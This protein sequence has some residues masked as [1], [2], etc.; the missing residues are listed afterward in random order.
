MAT[1]DDDGMTFTNFPY[2]VSPRGDDDESSV[3]IYDGLD[4]TPIISVKSATKVTPARSSLNLFDEILIEEGT[5]KEASYND[6]QAEHEKCQQQLQELT[7]KLQEIQEQN[8]ALQNEN[9]SLKKNISA[10]IKTARVEINRKDEEISNLQRRL[11]EFSVHQNTYART[12]FSGSTNNARNF[13]GSKM[14]NKFRDLLPENKART[15]FRTNQALPN[16][17]HCSYTYMDIENKKFPSE[18]GDTLNISQSHPEQLYNDG[19]CTRLSNVDISYDK[20]KGKKEMKHNEHLSKENDCKYKTKTHQNLGSMADGKLDS[21]GKL[22]VNP[23]KTVKNGMWKD[24]KDLKLKSRPCADKRTD[25]VSSGREKQPTPKDR[26]LAKT[27]RSS[28]DRTEKSLNRNQKVQNKEENSKGQKNRQSDRYLEQ[29]R[30]GKVSSPP[31]WARSPKKLSKSCVE[32][33]KRKDSDCRRNKE[34]SDHG[35]HGGRSS[36]SPP[37]NFNREQKRGHSKEDSSRSESVNTHTKSGRHRTEEKR[38]NEKGSTSEAKNSQNERRDS[39]ETT[40][41]TAKGAIK[42]KDSAQKEEVKSSP[43]EETVKVVEGLER[44]IP[45]KAKRDEELKS[46]DLKLSFMQTLNLTLSPAKKQTDKLKSLT[47]STNECDSEIPDQEVMVAPA[48]AISTSTKQRKTPLLPIC[49]DPVQTKLEQITPVSEVKM[50]V[51]NEGLPETLN[52]E[53]SKTTSYPKTTEM[54]HDETVTE[55][56]EVDETH[57]ASGLGSPLDQDTLPDNS[58]NDLETVSSVDF[59]SYSVIDEINGTDSDSLMDERESSNW[60]DEKVSVC[61]KKEEK[62]MPQKAIVEEGKILSGNVPATNQKAGYLKPSFPDCPHENRLDTLCNEDIQARY[63]NPVSV[64]DDNSIMSIDLNHMRNI[65]KAISPLSSPMRPLAKAPRMESPYKGPVKSFNIESAVVYPGKKQSSELNKENQKPPCPDHHS[66]E[67]S[68]LSMSTDELEEGEIV[69]DNNEPKIEMNS[70]NSKKSRRRASPDRS[71]LAKST[72]NHRAMS[73]TSSKDTGKLASGK[74]SKENLKDGTITSSKEMKKNKGVSIDSLEKIVQITVAPSTVHEFMQ[75]LRAIRKQVRKSYMKFK[76]Q[77]PVQHFHRIIDSAVLNFTSLVKYLD[78]S[79]MSKSSKALKLNL[80]DIIESKLTRIKVNSAIEHLFEQQQ[81]DMKKKLWKLVDEQLDYLFDKIKKILLKLCNLISFGNESDEGK[82]DKKTKE[83]PQSLTNHKSDRQKSKK[84]V[85]NGRTEKPEEC[86]P[87]RPVVSNQ[88]SKRG[89][90]DTNKMGIHKHMATNCKRS[91]TENPKH[92]QIEG[93][94]CKENSIQDTALKARNYKKEGSHVVGDPHKSDISCGPLTEQQMSGLTFNLVNDA[95][96]GEMFKSLLQGSDLSGKN[97]FID[98]S[99][100]EFRTPEKHTQDDQNCENDPAYEAEEQIPRETRV[101]SRVL[102]GIKWPVVSP[103]RDSAF[104]ARLQMPIDPDILDESCMFEIPASPALKKGEC[105]SEKPKSLVSSILLEDLAVSLTIPSPLKSDAHLSF[106]KPDMFGSVPEDVL[107]A[108]FSEDAHLEE[109]DASEQDIHLALESDNSSN[110]SSCSSSWA[111]TPPAP[112]FQYCPSLPMQAVIMEKSNDHFIV[113]IRRAAPSTSPVVDQAN[114]ANELLTSFTEEGNSEIVSEE[115]LGT[116]NSK[117]IPLGDTAISKKIDIIDSEDKMHYCVGEE[118]ITHSLES[119]K[120]PSV[121]PENAQVPDLTEPQQEPDAP[122][123]ALETTEDLFRNARQEQPC[124]RPEFCQ[125]PYSNTSQT[126]GLSLL[127]PYQ[128]LHSDADPE[129]ASV[130]QVPPKE[131]GI[132]LDSSNRTSQH[133]DTPEVLKLPQAHTV[134]EFQQRDASCAKLEHSPIGYTAV[135]LVEELSSETHFD[136]CVNLTDETPIENEV[137]SWDLTVEPA[138]NARMG[139]LCKGKE[140]DKIENHPAAGDSPEHNIEAVVN[141]T[142]HLPDKCTAE[143][144]FEMETALNIDGLGCQI[145]LEKERKK[146]KKVIEEGSNAKRQKKESCEVTCKK[147]SKKSKETIPVATSTSGK[148][149]ASIRNKDPLSAASSV[150][151]SSLCAKNIIKKKGEVV[152]SWTR[153]DDR[154]ILLECQKKGPSGRTFASVALRLNK[155]PTQV[156]ERFRQLLKLFK[157][158]NCS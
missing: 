38:K 11:S 75:M 126:Q 134:K 44:Q 49:D 83:S 85:L 1:G 102:D 99:Q 41:K 136:M 129:E 59:D 28:N 56:G 84:P 116:L 34:A 68:Q 86:A 147:N 132:S 27:E 2:G 95:Q 131:L 73:T 14:K 55:I 70:E 87:P 96:M 94:L 63:S 111:S 133:E 82:L 47:K 18:K 109:E 119:V 146:R 69:S 135:P 130:L 92:S 76:I 52:T 104:L 143:E 144:N 21:H 7:K 20:E 151:P 35:L 120:E 23:E 30:S 149:A 122:N 46:K 157:M 58:F 128:A 139:S 117:S 16:E 112:G 39:K 29:Q 80:C 114:L 150:S 156:E 32:D 145:S 24:N 3:D 45:A 103:E 51:G 77:F 81:S 4:S 26:S 64:D 57:V 62:P 138:L 15:D 125:D 148:K 50:K 98:N 90:H 40:Q 54:Q 13:E 106:L 22:Q 36:L 118:Q 25:K 31:E 105:I 6:L 121:C 78:F 17:L 8:S 154:E 19:T 12:Y 42:I 72:R 158:S 91:Y 124:N 123:D 141:L 142:E 66:L 115:K 97:D 127:G 67:E 5:A 65:P 113:K 79:K 140:E 110:K 33:R 89:H 107:S 61:P 37:P 53:P 155:S 153:N 60:G 88:V 43:S 10:L 74:K 152:I 101:E 137:D 9:Q 48:E 71:N 100:W 93:E 108:H